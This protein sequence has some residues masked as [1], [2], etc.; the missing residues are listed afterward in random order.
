MGQGHQVHP[1]GSI[2][3][4]FNPISVALG[5]EATFV[6]R[7][8]DMDRQHMMET[9]RRAHDHKGAAFVEI[10]QNCNVFNDGAFEPLTA[11]ANRA[12]MLIPLVHGEQIRFGA[13]LEKGVAM[14]TDGSLRIVD[15][16]EVGEENI[17]VHDEANDRGLG[18]MLSRLSHGPHEPTPIGVFRAVEHAEYGTEVSRQIAQA[19]ERGGPQDIEALLHSGATW[20]V[21]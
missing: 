11:K 9:F 14:G 2:D 8:H 5:A 4:P 17:L 16:A 7:T 12:D 6:A 13:D 15:V 19:H 1:F 3:T 18:F 20:T 21:E 10:Y